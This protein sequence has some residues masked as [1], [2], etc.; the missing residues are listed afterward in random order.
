MNVKIARCLTV[1]ILLCLNSLG[2]EFL[3]KYKKENQEKILRVRNS[4]SNHIRNFVPEGLIVDDGLI[5][6]PLGYE[7]GV[8]VLGDDEI[9]YVITWIHSFENLDKV[10]AISAIHYL[11]SEKV[12]YLIRPAAYS[13]INVRTFNLDLGNPV[14][15]YIFKNHQ[16]LINSRSQFSFNNFA[17]IIRKSNWSA[18]ESRTETPWRGVKTRILEYRKPYFEYFKKADK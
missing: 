9:A 16:D 3:E 17:D 5:L 11:E 13:K 10:V 6:C 12:I 8:T 18:P 1:F 4:L 14:C 2:D 7:R 15:G